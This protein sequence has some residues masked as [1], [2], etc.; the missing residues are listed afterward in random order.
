VHPRDR[1]WRIVVPVGVCCVVGT[2][3]VVGWAAQPARFALGYAPTQPIPFSHRV[4]AGVNRVA[5]QY[6][7]T[8]A[9]RS[10]D[11][12]IPALQTCMN[13]HRAITMPDSTYITNDVVARLAT[14]TA[15]AWKRIYHLPDHVFF[16][17]RAH[18]NVG[19]QCQTCHGEVQ[20]M[21]VVRRVMNTRMGECLL[22]HR[23]PTPYLPPGSPVTKGPT[24][25]T[26]CHR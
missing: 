12:T 10:R 11:A 6:C 9:D 19:L 14:D 3:L 25:C 21:D 2:M 26:A 15:L 4:H 7:H 13:C 1:F 5:C 8:N 16:D 18:V 23:N 20:Q 24:Y 17:H 22:C